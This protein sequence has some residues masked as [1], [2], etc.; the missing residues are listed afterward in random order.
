MWLV[1][2]S[3]AVNVLLLGRPEDTLCARA[4]RRGWVGFVLTADALFYALRGERDHCQR[5][6]EWEAGR[7]G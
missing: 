4:Y 7:D 1:V 5:L 2:A 3:R 6:A